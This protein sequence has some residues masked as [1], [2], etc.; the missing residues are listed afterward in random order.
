MMYRMKQIQSRP[1]V[2][3]GGE[4]WLKSRSLITASYKV[5][6]KELDWLPYSIASIYE[7]VDCIDIATGPIKLRQKDY[8]TISETTKLADIIKEFDYDNKIKV[9]HGFWKDKQ[10]IQNKLL[11]VCTSKW[12]L[13]I[14]ADEVIQG[15]DK[16][17]RFAEEHPDGTKI[18]ARP[19]R[20]FNFWHDF[21][22]IAYSLNPI[23]PWAQYGLPHPFLIHRDIPGLNFGAFHTIPTDGF[24]QPVHSEDNPDRKQ[25]LGDVNVYHFGSVKSKEDMQS[26]LTFE[27]VRG[28][29]YAHEVADDP[30]F[31]GKMPPDMV[32]EDYT[33]SYP[34]VLHG[35][36]DIGRTRIRVTQ[37]KP[38]YEFEEVE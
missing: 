23:S 30:W 11:E 26:K 32:L 9:Y 10:E 22:H 8:D 19:S 37:S 14:D 15:M 13:F 2:A 1:L 4:T 21:K 29:A 16:V 20:F 17:R 25:L 28:V 36:K 31:S 27:K 7:Y 33:F 18:Y 24:G 5:H 12:M 38:H 3:G 34:P 35:H 6:E